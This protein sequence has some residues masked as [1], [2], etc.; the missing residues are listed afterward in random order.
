MKYILD[1]IE[2][3]DGVAI[4]TN[5]DG[6]TTLI[7]EDGCSADELEMFNAWRDKY[8]EGKPSLISLDE[9]KA[10]KIAQ[11]DTKCQETIEAGFYSSALGAE[12]FYRFNRA[13]DQINF[14]QQGVML[15]LNPALNEIYWKTEDAGVLKH[16]RAQFLQVLDDASTNKTST[17]AKYWQLKSLIL[18]TESLEDLD[19][20]TW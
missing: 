2:I 3:N 6:S 14:S 9:A 17:I 8:P 1:N 16:T 19:L 12:H 18:S 4:V 13:E 15:T 5:E 20:I 10:L 11:F 7:P